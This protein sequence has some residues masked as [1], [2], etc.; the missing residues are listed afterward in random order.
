MA[1]NHS[2]LLV[3]VT[4]LPGVGKTTFARA[5]AE[6]IRARHLNTDIIRDTLGLRG[7]YDDNSKQKIYR[8]MEAQTAEALRAG[9]R[10]VVDGTFYRKELRAPY[11]EIGK[12]AEASV[13]WLAI[14]APEAVVKKRVSQKRD[15]SEADYVVYLKIKDAWEPLD[16]PHLALPSAPL[17]EMLDKAL[18][19]LHI[20]NS[21]S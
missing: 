9:E 2:P 12:Q 11:R 13:Y 8:A 17:E 20:Q 18:R 7:R 3:L 4:G 16:Q 6:K 10:V 14:E 5:L 21:H 1:T 19:Y 15:Y